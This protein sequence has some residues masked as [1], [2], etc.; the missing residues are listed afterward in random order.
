MTVVDQAENVGGV[1]SAARLREGFMR[2]RANSTD[3]EQREALRDAIG[4]IE[5]RFPE[6]EDV[7]PGGAEKFARER[8][9]GRGARSPSHEGRA[10]R[11][12]PTKH[13]PDAAPLEHAARKSGTPA[14]AGAGAKAKARPPATDRGAKQVPAPP[15]S[16]FER[17]VRA[18]GGRAF[19]ETGIPTASASASQIAMSALGGTVGLSAAY[20][21][22]H[23]AESAGSGT[24]PLI[25]LLQGA[26][27][28]LRRV[29][30]PFDFFGPRVSQLAYAQ[31]TAGPSAPINLAAQL[32]QLKPINTS[33]QH[34]SP[35]LRAQTR[36][37]KRKGVAR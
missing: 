37:L 36:Q 14:A 28:F 19:R 21:L 23:S 22:L 6:L 15:S 31:A 16:K 5:I 32:P 29:I 24:M 34:I 26:T 27:A 35:H 18:R 1:V 8:G 9:H 4:T 17:R 25:G 30:G 13:K 2:R 12:S 11:R 3:E 10:R 20:L 33:P 7:P